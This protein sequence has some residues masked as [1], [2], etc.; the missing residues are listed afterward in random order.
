[1]KCHRCLHAISLHNIR[2]VEKLIINKG[3]FWAHPQ[4]DDLPGIALSQ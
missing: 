1:M 4:T 2:D 3:S